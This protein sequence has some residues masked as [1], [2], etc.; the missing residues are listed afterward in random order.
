MRSISNAFFHQAEVTQVDRWDHGPLELAFLSEPA[1]NH[2][3]WTA[4]VHDWNATQR[5]G[6]VRSGR[7]MEGLK[8]FVP[9]LEERRNPNM[10]L[11]PTYDGSSELD[12]MLAGLLPDDV[13]VRAGL[14]RRRA[15]MG[16]M[17]V[18]HDLPADY[19]AR[20]RAAF[21]Q[22]I[23]TRLCPLARLS[24]GAFSAR[25]PLRLLA[26]DTPYW[27]HRLYRLALAR[28]D[29]FFEPTT[30]EDET[31]KPLEELRSKILAD[32][33]EDERHLFEVKRPLMGGDVW[34]EFDADEREDVIQC[35][36]DG[37]GVLESL[38]PVVELLHRHR[39]H[40]DFSAAHSWIKEDFERSFYSKRAKVKV[41]LVETIDDAPAYTLEPNEP[42]ESVLFRDVI[43][44]LDQKERR[45]VVALRSGKNAS[46]IAREAG[47]RG[48]ASVSRRIAALK[49]KV[50]RLL[51]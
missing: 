7:S 28:R 49:A 29:D 43:A 44:V 46:T 15:M 10:I 23:W 6:F 33:P 47:L 26:G 34:D 24:E 18:H 39:T 2:L 14:E 4:H 35:A 38:E 19:G 50:A 5:A 32:L 9:Y 31:W 40:D 48:H 17:Y 37:D 21:A 45:L 41:D 11:V 12:V 20:A 42:Y 16:L 8:P 27:A 36:I 30:H 25:S 13:L 51:N 1:T 22:Y 3:E